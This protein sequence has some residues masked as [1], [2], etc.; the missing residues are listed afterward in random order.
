[1]ASRRSISPSAARRR[2]R[3]LSRPAQNRLWNLHLSSQHDK[4][5]HTH[6]LSR[7]STVCTRRVTGAFVL[8]ASSPS[9]SSSSSRADDGYMENALPGN[10]PGLP[11][12]RCHFSASTMRKQC[13]LAATLWPCDLF[14]QPKNHLPIRLHVLAAAPCHLSVST[15]GHRLATVHNAVRSSAACS[16]MPCSTTRMPKCLWGRVPSPYHTG[17][18]FTQLLHPQT[19]DV[20][21]NRSHVTSTQLT[22]LPC[23]PWHAAQSG[24]G[25]SSALVIL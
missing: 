3:L 1:V 2:M 16:V 8:A 21:S 23:K 7:H 13:N 12:F 20:H 24:E 25:D 6:K 14:K 4:T 5:L 15:T 18:A 11:W 22:S 19:V 17:E 10:E 9:S